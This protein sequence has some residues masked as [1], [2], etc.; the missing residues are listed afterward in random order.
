LQGFDTRSHTF[1]YLAILLLLVAVV[2]KTGDELGQSDQ[3][4]AKLAVGRDPQE[5]AA[6]LEPEIVN[7]A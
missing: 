6:E 5:A 1:R 4:E 2:L 7:A 3:H